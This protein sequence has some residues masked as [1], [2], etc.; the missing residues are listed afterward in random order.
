MKLF[1]KRGEFV[2]KKPEKILKFIFYIIYAFILVYK[3]T[4]YKTV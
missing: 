2:A 4:K 3:K 1:T